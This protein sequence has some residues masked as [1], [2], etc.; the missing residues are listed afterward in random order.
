[1]CKKYRPNIEFHNCDCG[2]PAIKLKAGSWQCARCLAL[3]DREQDESFQ[4]ILHPRQ[5][6]R[7]HPQPEQRP[8]PEAEYNPYHWLEEVTA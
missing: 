2:H 7:D 8:E 6:E 1:M 3:Q 4:R 5:F